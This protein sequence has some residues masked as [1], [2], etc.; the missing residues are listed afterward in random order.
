MSAR[1]TYYL[2]AGASYHSIPTVKDLPARMKVFLRMI[3]KQGEVPG[4]LTYIEQ[5]KT[6]KELVEDFEKY[7]TPDTLARNYHL[8]GKTQLLDS[9]K[10]LLS[11]YLIFEQLQKNEEELENQVWSFF[12]EQLNTSKQDE[13]KVKNRIIASMAAE[14]DQR[15][16]SFFATI[17]TKEKEK[18]RLPGNVNVISWNYD[19][20]IERAFQD[21][22]NGHNSLV[23]VQEK[24]DVYPMI[25]LIPRFHENLE[26]FQNPSESFDGQS[27]SVLKLNGTGAFANNTAE[28]PFDFK[29]LKLNDAWSQIR[30]IM[31][32]K[33]DYTN[34]LQFAWEKDSYSRA[35]VS[36]TRNYATQALKKSDVVVV[37]GYSFPDFN[38]SIDKQIF[39][40]FKGKKLYIQDPAAENI[41]QKI[42]GVNQNIKTSDI[43]TITNTDN[44][45][46][47]YEFWEE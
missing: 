40:G 4:S 19:S 15:Y 20:Q 47:P 30:E 22:C 27:F 2:G 25:S 46:I 5:L 36:L 41:A 6:Y 16:N 29:N 21:F 28:A 38:R 45:F 32:K 24:L 33:S 9:L 42:R 3:E 26:N 13:E 12:P 35:S 23:E 10:R 14:L 43:V 1:I 18:I 44:F 37:I 8:T 31:F 34:R 17:L 11:C 7:V 39:S